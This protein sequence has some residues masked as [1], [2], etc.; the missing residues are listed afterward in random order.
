MH[1]NITWLYGLGQD[2]RK[3]KINLNNLIESI[4][5][6]TYHSDK[7]SYNSISNDELYIP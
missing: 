7:H 6:V 3:Y 4:L 1:R 5:R 2:S